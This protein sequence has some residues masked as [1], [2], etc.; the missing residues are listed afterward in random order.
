MIVSLWKYGIVE[1]PNA[2]RAWL[3]GSARG[4][5]G[6]GT[7]SKHQSVNSHPM[8]K[9]LLTVLLPFVLFLGGCKN[10]GYSER[11]ELSRSFS[12]SLEKETEEVL[13]EANHH[14]PLPL[15]I[16]LVRSRTLK[17]VSEELESQLA[18]VHRATAF[19]SFLP[20]LELSYGRAVFNKLHGEYGPYSADMAKT[21]GDSASVMLT[22]PVFVPTAW[23]LFA[24]SQYGIRIRD[25]IKARA[26]E[27]LDLATASV[28]HQAVVSDRLRK[29]YA[30][31]V[32]S[33]RAL[34]NRLSAL[35]QE[36]LA[37]ESDAARAR[38]RLAVSSVSLQA[39][40]DAAVSARAKLCEMMR[41]W[42]LATFEVDG[43]SLA[44]ITKYDWTFRGTNGTPETVNR[45]TVRTMKLEEL[46]WQALVNRKELYA[47]DQAVELRKTQVIQALADFL[48]NV[49]VGGGGQ[50]FTIEHLAAR[51]WSG[52]LIG[53]WAAFEGFRS[54]QNY[55]AAKAKRSAE[56]QLREDR[57]LAV[58]TATIE[59][60]R[61]WNRATDGLRAAE[62]VY[63]AA[64]LVC[65]DSERLF[66]D[67]QETMSHVLDRRADRDAA[68]VDAE[69]A[70]YAVALAELSLR[71]AIGVGIGL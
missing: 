36:G 22:Q 7:S 10:P 9:R 24:E 57:M 33:D 66:E 49:V 34:T 38:A 63:A 1:L 32:E 13:S 19:S 31:Q 28:Y 17:L 41:L 25:L 23:I 43:E 20:N 39:A 46:I 50:R 12:E 14:I 59:A 5:D 40:E 6:L 37:L 71:Q 48:P 60:W 67:G 53:T 54:V 11:A 35:V 16:N 56:F 45:E 27:M 2:L 30:L 47:E 15:A 51:Y 65:S 44:A 52:S 3:G 42:P 29:T 58:I 21:A 70:R 4:L 64:E 62:E 8:Y 18:R 26:S 61:N 55:R 68:Q 69:K